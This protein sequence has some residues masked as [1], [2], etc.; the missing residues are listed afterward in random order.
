MKGVRDRQI[1]YDLRFLMAVR[2][3]AVRENSKPL[4]VAIRS[5]F[6]D[7]VEANPSRP[8]TTDDDLMK[9]SAAAN[10]LGHQVELCLLLTHE[11]GHRCT[12][13][14]RLRATSISR[15]DS[16]VACGTRQARR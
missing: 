7:P 4:L 2:K 9:L 11:T 14:G 12:A 8:I 1:E 16:E 3:W 6:S 15:R 5:A 13:V 10:E